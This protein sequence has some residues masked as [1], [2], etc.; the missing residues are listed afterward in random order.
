MSGAHPARRRRHRRPYVPGR[1]AGRAAAHPRLCASAWS[2]TRAGAGFGDRLPAVEVH[3]ISAGGLA[4]GGPVRPAQRHAPAW[5]RASSRR[6]GLV[7][8][9]QPAPGRGLRRLCLGADH[10]GRRARRH[11]RPLLHEQNAVLGRANRLLAS[12]ARADRHILRRYD[13]TL[14][15]SHAR[16]SPAIRCARPSPPW[17]QQPMPRRSAARFDLLVLGGSQGARVFGQLAAG[18]H[19]AC[20]RRT[21]ASASPR[22]AMPGRRIWSRCAPPMR[23]SAMP[24]R[25]RDLLRRHGRAARPRP[26]GH[27]AQRRLD[28]GRARRRRP[29]RDPDALSLRHRRSPDGQCPGFCGGG[30]RL[31][32]AGSER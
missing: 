22:P 6:A 15:R 27:R 8:R 2:P 29:A 13:S 11:R 30:C 12:R 25:A 28:R 26:S 32:D 7:A 18:R 5:S 19:R 21:S 16:A 14:G 4:G 20:C 3:R 31:A 9:L 1:S 10:A 17:R 24:R 23:R